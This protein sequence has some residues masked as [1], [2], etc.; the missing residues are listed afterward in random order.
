MCN[1]CGI[2][3]YTCK[4]ENTSDCETGSRMTDLSILVYILVIIFNVSPWLGITG[5]YLEMPLLVNRTP[6]AW[7]LPSYITVT[8]NAST[9]T[10]VIF[11]VIKHFHGDR[12]SEAAAIYF[13]VA[14]S[15]SCIFCLAF[16]W[17]ISVMTNMTERSVPLLV[18]VSYLGIMDSLSL[19]VFLPY[20][21]HFD[22]RYMSAFFVGNGMNRVILTA[23]SRL[24]GVGE[25]P[26]C[27]NRTLDLNSSSEMT[28]PTEVIAVYPDPAF[29]I[30]VFFILVSII[31]TFSGVSFT[32]LN[33]ASY[34]KKKAQDS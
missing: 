15:S 2:N 17:D 1:E 13:I 7:E 31:I 29:S 24:Q 4:E 27:V 26:D 10:A 20:M 28:M 21:A 3:A 32:L 9:L 33:Y 25:S 14:S 18:L 11:S 34:F 8:V 12:I 30:R 19:V 16:V 22:S 6:E 5:V 23:I